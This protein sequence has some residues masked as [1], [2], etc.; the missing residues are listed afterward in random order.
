MDQKNAMLF[1]GT[2]K[3]GKKNGQGKQTNFAANQSISGVWTADQ[4]TFVENFGIIQQ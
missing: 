4:L 1:S 2:K 3:D